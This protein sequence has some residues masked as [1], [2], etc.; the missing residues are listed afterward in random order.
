MTCLD[1]AS[2]LAV[3]GHAWSPGIDLIPIAP[4]ATSTGIVEVVGRSGGRHPPN[5]ASLAH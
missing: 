1:L 3:K 4:C 2:V 5:G